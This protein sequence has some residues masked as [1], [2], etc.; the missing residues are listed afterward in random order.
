MM[1]TMLK[2]STDH[3]HPQ[4]FGCNHHL[5]HQLHH[6]HHHLLL[7]LHRSTFSLSPRYPNSFVNEY[8]LR[9]DL[10]V[11]PTYDLATV[12]LSVHGLP[13]WL[14]GEPSTLTVLSPSTSAQSALLNKC[15]SWLESN[16]PPRSW[17]PSLSP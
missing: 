2:R 6:H 1:T 10:N 5:R 17:V 7:S 11:R 8:H 16:P 15:V 9:I 13:D 14:S 12:T 3:A 4:L